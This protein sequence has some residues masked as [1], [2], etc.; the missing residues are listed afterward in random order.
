MSRGYIHDSL[1]K[2]EITK[3]TVMAAA[4]CLPTRVADDAASWWLV[5]YTRR[6]HWRKKFACRKLRTLF[7]CVCIGEWVQ[8]LF[9]RCSNDFE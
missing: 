6:H 8:N 5:T 1:A 7:D 9:V 3:K 2:F 4:R